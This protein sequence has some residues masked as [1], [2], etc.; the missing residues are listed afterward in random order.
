MGSRRTKKTSAIN[1]VREA[2]SAGGVNCVNGVEHLY[3]GP[4]PP[5]IVL[6][7]YEMR[8]KD[9]SWGWK[10]AQPLRVSTTLLE[11]HGSS[12]STHMAAPNYLGLQFRAVNIL[13]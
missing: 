10:M 2:V 8:S 12:P 4:Q 13:F 7:Q 3:C 1:R 9:T 5:L 11:D 6:V